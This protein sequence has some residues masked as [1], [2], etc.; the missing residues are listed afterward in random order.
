MM[1]NE[2]T[3]H[4]FDKTCFL[5]YQMIKSNSS[6]PIYYFSYGSNNNK[7][8]LLTFFLESCQDV[9]QSPITRDSLEECFQFHSIGL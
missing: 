4:L 2:S 8:Q 6:K 1:R 7:D 3:Q 5:P 9:C